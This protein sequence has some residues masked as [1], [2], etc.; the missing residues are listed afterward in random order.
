M[1]M[2]SSMTHSIGS[3]EYI[4][5]KRHLKL[6]THASVTLVSLN[7]FICSSSHDFNCIEYLLGPEQWITAGSCFKFNI[8]LSFDGVSVDDGSVV[9]HVEKLSLSICDAEVPDSHTPK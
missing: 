2:V 4:Y 3:F 6:T 7:T 1:T 9:E 8:L 5:A